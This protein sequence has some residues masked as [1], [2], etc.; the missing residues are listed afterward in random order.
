LSAWSERVLREFPKDLSRL[1]VAAD[2]DDVLLD[3]QILASLREQGFELVPYDDPVV[4]RTDYEERFRQAWDRGEPGASEALVLHLQSGAVEDLP[5]DYLRDGRRIRLSLADL[6]PRLSYAVVRQIGQE[7]RDALF[8]AQELHAPQVLGDAATRDFVLIHIFEVSPHLLS[9]PEALWREL[10][11][12]HYSGTTL[13]DVLASHFAAVLRAK[14]AFRELDVETLAGSRRAF[15]DSV[16]RAWAQFLA[17][18]GVEL[19]DGDADPQPE[20]YLP[21]SAIPFDHPDLRGGLDLMF[22]EALL[23]PVRV[24]KT[25]ATLPHWASVGVLEQSRSAATLAAEDVDRVLASLPGPDGSY[26]EWLQLARRLGDLIFRLNTLPPDVADEMKS[27]VA[28][29][30]LNADEH[31]RGWI[32]RHYSDLSSLPTAKAPVMVHHVPRFLSHR[33][34]QGEAKVAL[35]V[36]DGLAI[37]QWVQIR[38][39]LRRRAPELGFEESA[40]FAWAPTLTSVSRQALFSGLRPRE[41]SNS[42]ETTA[43]EPTLWSRH[44]QD[45]GLRANEVVYRRGLKRVDQLAEVSAAI[46]SPSVKAAGLVVDTVDELMHGAILGKRGVA[47]QIASW[48]ESGFVER[49]FRSLLDRGFSVYLTADHGNVEAVGIGRLGQGVAAEL[50][51]ERV[52]TYRSTGLADAAP[53]NVDAFR[54][55]IPGLPSDLFALYAGGRSAFVNRGEQIVAHGGLSVEELIVPFV[56]VTH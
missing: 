31:L 17:G 19:V 33:R 46:D 10:F 45:N 21:V 36:F 2:P 35:V 7:H 41:F 27:R 13:P 20:P 25:P 18:Q 44:W 11:R 8:E 40:C 56:R 1:W 37:D 14:P 6:F 12:L 29:L 23:Q 52:R 48:C 9:K 34:S 47:N 4:F 51:G 26:R 54:L 53:P 50:R 15:L 39:I 32:L 24:S 42:I 49:L 43:Q 55:D 28:Q 38:E 16:Q 3:E 30:Q 22:R 5:W